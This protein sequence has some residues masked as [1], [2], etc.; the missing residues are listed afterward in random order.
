LNAFTLGLPAAA[1]PPRSAG[2]LFSLL[3]KLEAGRLDLTTPEGV[4]LTF[5]G[6][7]P[8]PHA[9]LA[10]LDWRAAGL[11]MRDA[12]IGLFAAWRDGLVATRDLTAVLELLALNQPALERVFYGHPVRAFLLRLAHALRANT[13]AGSRRN[14][15][16][17]YDLGNAFYALWLDPTMSYSSALFAPGRDLVAAQQAKYDRILD[18]L[19]VRREHHVLEVGC[20]WGGFAERAA[21]TR[22]CRVSGVTISAAQLE[23]ARE[24]I[25]RAGLSHLVDL[26]FR[27]Y[28]DLQGRYD[29]IVSIEM[30]EAVGERYWPGYFR[31]LHDRLLPGGRAAVQS[32][33][34][35]PEA[36]ERYRRGSDFIRE[37]I[38]PGGMLPS[39]PRLEAHARAAG[40]EVR[41]TFDFGA[42]YAET[43]RRWRAAFD[44]RE[45]EVRALGFDDAFMA[46]WRFYLHYC[47]AGFNAGRVSVVQVELA[48]GS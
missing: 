48:R 29:R 43:L 25:E 42:D 37:H 12:E 35:A 19:D 10:L 38:F 20:G 17:H 7:A 21:A 18:V 24:R 34:I 1:R 32:I 6:A 3:A 14:I 11:A 27:D 5:E 2:A 23:Y 22:D 41:G 30:L 16:A 33:V 9:E 4:R 26:E 28:R 31:M 8:G 36:F 40:L 47:E 13:R 44:A 45:R 15:F 46:T 39:L